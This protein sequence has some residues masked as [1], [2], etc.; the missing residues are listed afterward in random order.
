MIEQDHQVF[1]PIIPTRNF[2][3][4][5]QCIPL[6][7]LTTS[8]TQCQR[9][10]VLAI[11]HILNNA[12]AVQLNDLFSTKIT[13]HLKIIFQDGH[14]CSRSKHDDEPAEARR[15]DAWQCLDTEAGYTHRGLTFSPFAKMPKSSQC[16]FS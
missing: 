1:S 4:Q 8:A 3:V 15:G 10:H 11:F 5:A 7:I 16:N 9:M 12:D 6:H 13:L 14:L 2:T